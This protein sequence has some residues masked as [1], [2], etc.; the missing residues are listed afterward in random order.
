MKQDAF[1]LLLVNFSLEYA[2][3]EVHVF[4]NVL[5]LSDTHRIL[6]YANDVNV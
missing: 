4:K 3:R 5:K 2:I 1:S 6:V